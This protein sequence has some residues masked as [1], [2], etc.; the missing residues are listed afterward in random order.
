MACRYGQ[1]SGGPHCGQV[2]ARNVTQCFGQSPCYTIK[3]LIKTSGLCIRD[4]DSGGPL[5]TSAGQAQGTLVGGEH[6]SCDDDENQNGDPDDPGENAYFQPVTTT[7]GR[8]HKTMLTT[9]GS[10]KPTVNGFACAT[11]VFGTPNYWV[12]TFDNYE[13]QGDTDWLWTSGTSSS[14]WQRFAGFCSP[15]NWV[16]VNLSMTNDYGT[17]YK[18]ASFLCPGTVP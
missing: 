7:L 3:G 11:G 4:G 15:G 18:S 2:A 8:F 5:M 16:Y 12:C 6:N 9:H 10:V 13:S 14:D 17:R 1:A